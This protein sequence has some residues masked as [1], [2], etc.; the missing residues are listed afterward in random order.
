MA[1]FEL[2]YNELI[3]K[4]ICF[5]VANSKE[6]AAAADKFI[7]DNDIIG[8]ANLYYPKYDG[9]QPDVLKNYPKLTQKEKD[10]NDIRALIE[11]GC[12][13]LAIELFH[14][15]RYDLLVEAGLCKWADDEPDNPNAAQLTEDIFTKY[16]TG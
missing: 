6:A 12:S 11:I 9:E 5:E 13:E 3:E 7:E 8:G 15:E 16:I 1:K 14:E 4:T 10:R 2:K